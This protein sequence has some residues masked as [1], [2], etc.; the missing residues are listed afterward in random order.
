MEIVKVEWRGV[1]VPYGHPE[2]SGG[3]Q[4]VRYGLLLWVQTDNGLMGV[5]E[6]SPPGSAMHW[7]L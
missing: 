2:D 5:G 1:K 4:L 7:H 6:A 3:R